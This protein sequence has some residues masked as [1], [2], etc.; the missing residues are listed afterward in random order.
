MADG[1]LTDFDLAT[2]VEAT[3]KAYLVRGST[4][5]QVTLATLLANIPSAMKTA[6][7]LYL[8]G[9]PQTLAGAGTI[10]ATVTTTKISNTGNVALS[11]ADGLFAGQIKFIL[12]T[13]AT[14]TSTLSGA[15]L[16]VTSIAFDLAGKTAI[17]FW[18]GTVWWP[19]AGTATI[20]Y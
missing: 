1:K 5:L 4:D 17:L 7:P 3:D 19:L 10:N 12:T 2:T 8:G 15:N 11:I 14:N 6:S 18:D 16:A 9:T 13:S 20:N